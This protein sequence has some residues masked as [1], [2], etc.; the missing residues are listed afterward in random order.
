MS[1]NKHSK[2]NHLL[3]AYP[4]GIVLQSSWLSQ[5]GYSS[6]LQ[7]RYRNS[8]WLQ[9]IG[10]G[11]MA[12]AADKIEYEGAVYALQQQSN[13]SIHPGGITALSYL[14]K[15]HYLQL[16][17]KNVHLFAGANERLP[18]WVSAYNWGLD[19]NYHASDFLPPSL[20]LEPYELK[21]FSIN[22]SGAIRAIMEC[23]YLAPAQQDLLECLQL[24]EAL[25]NIRPNQAQA[26]LQQCQSIKVKRLF[27][28]MAE[29][30]GHSWFKHLHLD[31]IDLGIG[32][33]SI[34]KNGVYD[35]KYQITIPKELAEY[36]N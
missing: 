16:S 12:I 10:K 24:M 2:I 20:G 27:L 28:F 23:L 3:T 18:K 6:A 8:N 34:V 7:Q 15:A 26:L 1:I 9:P 19:I 14:G 17:I 25:N 4:V 36:G 11:A 33:R 35:G 13:L 32:K 5:Q 31:K 30:V 22:I 21:N 29:K